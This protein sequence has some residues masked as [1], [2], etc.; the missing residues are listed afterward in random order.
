MLTFKQPRKL[1]MHRPQATEFCTMT[2]NIS[3]S[4]NME[5]ASEVT[6]RFSE[7]LWSPV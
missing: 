2:P 1:G 6:R 7:H 5:L 4:S 3:E